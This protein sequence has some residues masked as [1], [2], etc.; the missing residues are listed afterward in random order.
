MGSIGICLE[1]EDMEALDIRFEFDGPLRSMNLG[2][3]TTILAV[4]CD[5][6][7]L[8][9]LKKGEHVG[10]SVKIEVDF[11]PK[12]ATASVGMEPLLQWTLVG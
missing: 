1:I 6:M 9:K 3:A 8:S 4:I 5:M 11:I 2:Y 12:L 7:F 10:N